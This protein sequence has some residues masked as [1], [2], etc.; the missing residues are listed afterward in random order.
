M[1]EA[2]IKIL[3]VE[4]DE[5]DFVITQKYLSEIKRWRFNLDWAPDFGAAWKAMKRGEH[6]VYL[7][8][9]RLGSRNGLELIRELQR[10]HIK[11]PVILLT[12]QGGMDVDL[13]AM[14]AGAA[15]YLEKDQMNPSMLERSIRYAIERTKTLDALKESEARFRGIFFGAAIGIAL[16]DG[17]GRLVESNPALSKMLGYRSDELL[18]MELKGIA[19]PDDAE[20]N[21]RL[22]GELVAGKRDY[23][24]VENRYVRKNGQ[25]IWGR[26]TVSPLLGTK[27]PLLFAIAMMEDVTERKQGKEALRE[28]ERKLRILSSKLLSAQES[29]RK[30]IAQELHDSIG[31]SLAAIKYS[32]ERKLDDMRKGRPPDGVSLEQVISIVLE[33]IREAKRISTNL[34]PSILDDLGILATIRWFCREF[35]GVYSA[36]RIEQEISVEEE[37]I[38]EAHKTVIYRVM[39]EALNNI[40]KHSGADRVNLR[41]RKK[42]SLLEL[43]IQDNGKGFNL[44]KVLTEEV[45][46]GSMGLDSMRERTELSQGTFDIWTSEGAGTTITASWNCSTQ[47]RM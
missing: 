46:K 42:G 47:K 7:V 20:N 5:D 6:D 10:D 38:P 23:Y 13:E 11:A 1:D 17:R 32:L 2:L 21:E 18:H 12:G 28:S 31:A 15:D 29:E 41:V 22:Y 16:L 26:L 34:R 9:Y 3:L 35:Q 25:W 37:E 36:V 8:D 44:N 14:K 43:S 30:L 45:F 39:Q 24:Q 40:A 33:T 27:Q 19:H 4:D